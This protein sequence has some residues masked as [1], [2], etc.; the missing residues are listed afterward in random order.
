MSKFHKA[1]MGWKLKKGLI[2]RETYLAQTVALKKPR[3]S[4]ATKR[5]A[6]IRFSH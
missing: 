2:D 6:G 5:V 4:S 1:Y 3:Q